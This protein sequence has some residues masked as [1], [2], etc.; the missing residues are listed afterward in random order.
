LQISEPD[1]TYDEAAPCSM[2]QP[3]AAAIEDTD[4]GL[5]Q[6]VGDVDA[7]HD[8]DDRQEAD[9]SELYQDTAAAS[10]RDEPQD[11]AEEDFYQV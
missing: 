2:P 11:F 9:D 8:V 1:D 3:T 6:E 7:R 4:E 10:S 5:Y